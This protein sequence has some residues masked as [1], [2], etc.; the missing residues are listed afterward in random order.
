MKVN[1]FDFCEDIYGKEIE[2]E[3]IS[4]IRD[5]QKFNNADELKNKLC[6]D[7]RIARGFPL[8]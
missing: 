6:E 8:K 3:F 4:R 7:E 1:I 2:V 5:M